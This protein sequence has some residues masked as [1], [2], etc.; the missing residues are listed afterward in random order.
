MVY[1][2]LAAVRKVDGAGLGRACTF[3]A[4]V[5]GWQY[6][7]PLPGQ[8]LGCGEAGRPRAVSSQGP[9]QEKDNGIGP[10]STWVHSPPT[11][12][13]RFAAVHIEWAITL[14]ERQRGP[15][16]RLQRRAVHQFLVLRSLVFQKPL[17]DHHRWRVFVRVPSTHGIRRNPLTAWRTARGHTAVIHAQ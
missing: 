5:A 10:H 17:I 15:L 6:G 16:S 7:E 11:S 1:R 2:L 13:T 9:W 14:L 4:G 8:R 3:S 12:G